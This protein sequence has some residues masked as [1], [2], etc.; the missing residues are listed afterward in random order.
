M[1]HNMIF[2][3]CLLLTRIL[4][5][6]ETSTTSYF[7]EYRNIFEMR[8]AKLCLDYLKVMT[9]RSRHFFGKNIKVIVYKHFAQRGPINFGQKTTGHDSTVENENFDHCSLK[10]LTPGANSA[11]RAT[12]KL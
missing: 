9:V 8:L 2:W 6:I 11:P 3:T 4:S 10:R 12:R 1:L 7:E 5:I